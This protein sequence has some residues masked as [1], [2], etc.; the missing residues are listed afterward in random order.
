MKTAAPTMRFTNSSALLSYADTDLIGF[1]FD[2]TTLTLSVHDGIDPDLLADEQYLAC[3]P[4]IFDPFSAPPASTT[5]PRTTRLLA[6]PLN[7]DLCL[8]ARYFGR[9]PAGYAA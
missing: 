1:D 5:R 4:R 8:K 7:P 2:A 6:A 9:N 3:G